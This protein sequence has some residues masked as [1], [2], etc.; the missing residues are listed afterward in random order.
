MNPLLI[1]VFNIVAPEVF[2]LINS[3]RQKTN[4]ATGRPFTY[5]EVLEA[6]GIVLDKE[7]ARLM[8]DLA[9]DLADGAK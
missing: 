5:A 4:P 7:H 8:D 9:K 3:Q 1:S 2:S 6:E